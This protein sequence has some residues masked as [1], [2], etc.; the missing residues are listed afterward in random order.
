MKMLGYLFESYCSVF[1]LFES[2]YIYVSIYITGYVI[3]FSQVMLHKSK[4][5]NK[6]HSNTHHHY[7]EHIYDI[8]DTCDICNSR[9]TVT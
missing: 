7:M 2:I 3:T 8:Y 1:C 4:G 9:G 5:L 6:N